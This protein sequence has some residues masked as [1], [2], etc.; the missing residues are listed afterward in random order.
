MGAPVA[1]SA[2]A[3]S[4][5]GTSMAGMRLRT[6]KE[7]PPSARITPAK[8]PMGIHGR[9]SGASACAGAIGSAKV[10]GYS[11]RGTVR[12]A[13]GSVLATRWGCGL[14]GIEAEAGIAANSLLRTNFASRATSVATSWS[15]GW[16]FAAERRMVSASSLRPIQARVKPLPTRAS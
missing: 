5:A 13:N 2:N 7:M 14:R 15:S 3:G 16:T 6:A 8:A 4:V 12:G 1:L 9:G 11:D 10:R